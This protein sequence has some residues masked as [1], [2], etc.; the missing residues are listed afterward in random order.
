MNIRREAGVL[1][2]VCLRLIGQQFDWSN[3]IG[4]LQV[5][6]MYYDKTMF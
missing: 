6:Y 5:K 3:L 1:S 2:L 4:L